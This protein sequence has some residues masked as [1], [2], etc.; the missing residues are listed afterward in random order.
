MVQVKKVDSLIE[1]K[2]NNLKQIFL[3]KLNKEYFRE[4]TD[5]LNIKQDK[6]YKHTSS[7]ENS[8]LEY[9]HCM[10]CKGLKY[11]KNELKGYCN[12]PEVDGEDITFTYKA[13]RY[14]QKDLETNKYKEN[15]SLFDM[16][17]TLQEAKIKA[18]YTDDASRNETIRYIIDF[19]KNYKKEETKGI[20]LHGNFGCG[21]TY[22]VAA[23]FNELAKK[24]EKSAIIYFPEFLRTLKSSFQK[25]EENE[26]TFS[27]KYEYIKNIP[28]LLIDDI[29]AE[30]VTAW[31]RDE[32]LGTLLQHRMNE[33]LTTFFTSNLTITELENHLAV[34]QNKTEKVKARRIIERIKCL[35]TDIE[36]IGKSRR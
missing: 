19:L 26:A 10:A 16:P 25:Q 17:K 8:A 20:Y 3:N 6:L 2:E 27:E 35:T 7:L 5:N 28:Y 32:I 34:S 14:K 13:C 29:G 33:N 12:L 1:K 4:I 24:G 21:K 23:L 15:L 22:L 31:G 9:E 11:C 18:I 36:I 30:N